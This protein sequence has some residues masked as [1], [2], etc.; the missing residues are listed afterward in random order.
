MRYGE[1]ESS[2]PSE[3]QSD[4]EESEERVGRGKAT[5]NV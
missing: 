2:S 1:N 5:K 3:G 4:D